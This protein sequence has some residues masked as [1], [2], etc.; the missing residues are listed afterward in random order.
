M[1]PFEILIVVVIAVLIIGM[2]YNTT[3]NIISSKINKSKLSKNNFINN[4][5]DI[6]NLIDLAINEKTRIKLKINNKELRLKILKSHLVQN[7]KYQ[8]SF[9]KQKL[10]FDLVQL[11]GKTEV[12]WKQFTEGY[13]KA[14]FL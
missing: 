14:T 13:P 6:H 10:V 11:E 2:I 7:T 1:N 9:T 8:S 4:P 5:S 3:F 12:S